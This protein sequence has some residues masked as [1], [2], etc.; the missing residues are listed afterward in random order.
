MTKENEESKRGNSFMP[1]VLAGG[2]SILILG[3]AVFAPLLVVG[4]I[5]VLLALL[6]VF[7]AGLEEK[8]SKSEGNLEEYPLEKVDKEKTGMWVF[9]VS[10]ILLFGGLLTSYAFIRANSTYWPNALENHNVVIGTINTIVLLTSSLAMILALNSARTGNTTGTKIALASAFILGIVFLGIKLG[11]EW[12][13]EYRRG[14]TISS[15]LP[16]STYYAL[17]G[18]HGMHVAI[19]CVAITYLLIRA[20]KGQFTKTKNTGIENVGLYWHFVDIVWMFLF[21]IFYLL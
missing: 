13:D 1:I 19:G 7:K 11:F 16:E 17:V 6:K 5:I 21:T 4:F 8:Y 14:F 15:G 12:P 2:I 20:L 10:E 3:V 9:L 18:I